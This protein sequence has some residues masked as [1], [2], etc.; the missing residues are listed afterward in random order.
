MRQGAA[1][2]HPY[3]PAGIVDCSTTSAEVGIA[4]VHD[5]WRRRAQVPQRGLPTAALGT[6]FFRPQRS[7]VTTLVSG[8]TSAASS[9]VHLSDWYVT[10]AAEHASPGGIDRRPVLVLDGQ[11]AL[12][13]GHPDHRT[14]VNV[15]ASSAR[16]I[17]V[18]TSRAMK[19]RS[20]RAP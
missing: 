15:T 4:G 14:V 18:S 12:G 11:L 9:D 2:G 6:R 19:R 1:P 5:P 17:R 20:G 16:P 8:L 13:Q 10:E 7:H 3:R